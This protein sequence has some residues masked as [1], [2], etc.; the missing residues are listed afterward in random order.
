MRSAAGEPRMRLLVGVVLVALT[1]REVTDAQEV[2]GGPTS[3]P[4]APPPTSNDASASSTFSSSSSSSGTEC[5]IGDLI[6]GPTCNSFYM[7]VGPLYAAKKVKFLCAPGTV[8]D[9]DLNTCVHGI[10]SKCFESLP[11]STSAPPAPIPPA[12]VPPGPLTSSPAPP[13]PLT[14]SPSPPEPTVPEVVT[15]SPSPPGPTPTAG[16]CSKYQLDPTSVYECPEPGYYPSLTDCSRFYKCIVTM[17]CIMKGFMFRCPSNYRYKP[18]LNKCVKEEEAGSCDRLADATAQTHIVTPIVDLT[19]DVLDDFFQSDAYWNLMR[20]LPSEPQKVM[21]VNPS[22][23][24][25]ES[26]RGFFMQGL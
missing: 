18:S 21:A 14:S 8:F 2:N 25:R 10:G 24:R 1:S 20:Y 11:S 15:S 17:N 16:H 22:T 19:P 9:D 3:L 12:P 26:D 13:G 6:P 23:F 7:C 5:K 4:P